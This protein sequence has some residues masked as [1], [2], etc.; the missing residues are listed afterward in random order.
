M[1]IVV[2]DLAS[3]SHF[4]IGAAMG[5]DISKTMGLTI[6]GA[7]STKTDITIGFFELF[8]W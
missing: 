1:I 2:I 7:V 3:Q 5:L 4:F 6:D 8:L